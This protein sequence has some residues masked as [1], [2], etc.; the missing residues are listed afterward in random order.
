MDFIKKFIKSEA[1]CNKQCNKLNLALGNK[2]NLFT[3]CPFI[4]QPSHVRLWRMKWK[5]FPHQNL[6]SQQIAD[7]WCHSKLEIGY[8]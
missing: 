8:Y 7:S 5:E 6:N 1:Y 4:F 3:F 2:Q